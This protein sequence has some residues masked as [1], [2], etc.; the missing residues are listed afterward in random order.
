MLVCH[1]LLEKY[2]HQQTSHASWWLNTCQL[3]SSLHKQGKLNI[4]LPQDVRFQRNVCFN[5]YSQLKHNPSIDKK[6]H[7]SRVA[8]F[9]VASYWV[10]LGFLKSLYPEGND[11]H[12]DQHFPWV[13][14]HGVDRHLLYPKTAIFTK[15]TTFANLSRTHVLLAQLLNHNVKIW[16]RK[17]I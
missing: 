17:C 6:T 2:K 3:G 7:L 8:L 10:D 4:H 5:T 15:Q 13:V 14:T 1:S 11:L 9:A 12:I 16:V